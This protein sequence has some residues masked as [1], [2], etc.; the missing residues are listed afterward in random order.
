MAKVTIKPIPERYL[1]HPR[2]LW[3]GTPPIFTLEPGETDPSEQ[4]IQLARELFKL[5]DDNS[6]WWYTR[7]RT[8]GI[9]E[10]L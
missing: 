10:G 4:D 1:K 9:F 5:L 8:R 3:P 6:K 2:R 7:G